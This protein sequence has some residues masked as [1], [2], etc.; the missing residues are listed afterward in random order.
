MVASRYLRSRR[1][2]GFISVIAWFSLAGICLGVATL[3]IVMSVMNG[4]RQELLDRILGLNSHITVSHYSKP[5]TSF[6]SD[7]E[8]I[9]TLDGVVSA[10]PTIEGQVMAVNGQY[11]SGAIVRGIRLNDLQN[12][13][14]V[15]GNIKSGS[16]LNFS[17][18]DSVII[19]SRLALILGLRV[20]DK[21][22]LISS[23]TNATFFGAIP[24]M[25][26]YRIAGLFEVGMYEYDSSVI[27]MPLNLA[28]SYFNFKDSVNRIEVM[29]NDADRSS[30]LAVEINDLLLDRLLVTDWQRSNAHFFNS[31]KVE[32]NVMFL[33]LTLI[34]IVAAFNVISSMIM[35]VNDK[36]R[37]IAIL[38]T[39][40]ASRTSIMWI[41]I[42]A[43]SVIGVI[44][45]I[46]GFILGLSFSLNIDT[47]KQWIENFS[48]AEL[49]SAEIYFLSQLPAIVDTGEVIMV[50]TISLS[51]SFLATIYPAWKATRVD[52]AHGVHH[53]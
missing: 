27:F 12:K 16:L 1:R 10:I 22:T 53:E 29:I 37:A 2:E 48:G 7:A 25:K 39:M 17:M 31:L 28:Q 8:L 40:G 19:G 3:I 14:L 30:D 44:G 52:P 26:E 47:I 32:R 46:L 45:T 5:I 4:F 6:D 11:S 24:R 18:N 23:Q 42:M 15:S 35:L 34:I 33:I 43:G 50:V 51:L 13:A 41:F 20:G 49:F 38:R 36:S 21:I 9:T